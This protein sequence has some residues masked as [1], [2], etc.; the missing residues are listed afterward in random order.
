MFTLESLGFALHPVKT[1][2]RSRILKISTGFKLID[3]FPFDIFLEEIEDQIHV[4]DEGL[5][6]PNLFALNPDLLN[7]TRLQEIA[8]VVGLYGVTFLDCGVFE[9]YGPKNKAA[10]VVCDYLAAMVNLDR[11]VVEYLALATSKNNLVESA[12]FM[13]KRWRP[14]SV[15][16][17]KPKIAGLGGTELEFDFSVDDDFVDVIS[18]TPNSS[19]HFIRKATSF[20]LANTDTT[21]R[22]LAVVDD[23]KSSEQANLEIALISRNFNAI[24]LSRLSQNASASREH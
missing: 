22:A 15:I 7:A 1:R 9:I 16:E 11:W 4:W 18:P 5:T 10:N 19:A 23:S 12:K 8:N 17:S 24:A 21:G 20:R 6:Y 3:E 2:D 13:F 14:S